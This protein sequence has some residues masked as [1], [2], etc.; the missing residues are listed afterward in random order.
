MNKG[1]YIGVIGANY[2][3]KKVAQLAYAVGQEIAKA[4]AVLV[5]GGLGGVMEAA[6]QGANDQGG[7]TIGILP[8]IDKSEANPYVDIPIVT[9]LGYARN[10]LVVRN[11][12]VVIAMPGEFGTLSEIAFCLK[13]GI[14]LI[15][16]SNWKIKGMIPAKNPEE[17]VKLALKQIK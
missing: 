6:C 17:A 2:C 9:G 13:L 14:P 5:C 16:L 3:N 7:K 10:L 15:S 4:E 11:S 8:G 1:I 12:Q